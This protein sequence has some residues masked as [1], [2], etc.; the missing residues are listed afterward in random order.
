MQK[1]SGT[2]P[3]VKIEVK[4][5]VK[6]EAKAETEGEVEPQEG[7]AG[8]TPG[9]GAGRTPGRGAKDE[10]EARNVFS[11]SPGDPLGDRPQVLSRC[12]NP[13]RHLQR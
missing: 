8:R 9:G 13:P 7:G 6:T 5:E 2:E 3:E 10:G 4:S 1:S 12:S 11:H